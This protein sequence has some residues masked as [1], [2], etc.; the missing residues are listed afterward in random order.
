MAVISPQLIEIADVILKLL[1]RKVVE[2]NRLFLYSIRA[3]IPVIVVV[4]A[5]MVSQ[6]IHVNG[7]RTRLV[8][9]AI[10]NV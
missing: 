8:R 3:I 1:L 4:I 5:P 2:F 6:I 7:L 9:K 10:V